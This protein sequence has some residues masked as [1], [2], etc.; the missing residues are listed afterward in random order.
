M[1]QLKVSGVSFEEVDLVSEILLTWSADV[2]QLHRQL[3]R[4]SRRMR[5]CLEEE[6]AGHSR[7]VIHLQYLRSTSFDSDMISTGNR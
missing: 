2:A 7:W 4:R 6:A 3:R 5:E 1:I